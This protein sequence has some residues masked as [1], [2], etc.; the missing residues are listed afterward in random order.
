MH[1]E[2]TVYHDHMEFTQSAVLAQYV[3]EIREQDLAA[4]SWNLHT[5]EAKAGQT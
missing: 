3:D 2:G 4:H 1:I 5:W